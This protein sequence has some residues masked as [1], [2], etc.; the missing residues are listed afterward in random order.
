MPRRWTLLLLLL[1]VCLLLAPALA[2]RAATTPH[3][4]YGFNVAGVD[5]A[6]LQAMGFDWIKLFGPPGYRLPLHVLIRVDATAAAASDSGLAALRAQ[7]AG[8]AASQGAYIEAYEIGNEPNL[9]ASYGWAA[10]PVAADYARVLCG[11]AEAIHAHDPQATVVS[12]GLAPV[13]RVT[14]NWQG[15]AGHNGAYQDEREFLREFIA[16]GGAACADA[17]GYHPYGYS[18]N[19]DAAPDIPSGNPDQNCDNGFCFRGVEKIHEILAAEGYADKPIW[20][21]EFGWIVTP[22]ADCL[23]HPSFQG[24][25]WQ[26]V[27][28]AEQAANLQGA[29]TYADAHMPWM[30]PMFVFNLNFNQASYYEP[31]EQMRF[32]AVQGR[33]AESALAGMPKNPVG[34]VLD[35]DTSPRVLLA[36]TSEQP[37]AL[38]LAIELRN[39]G[40]APYSFSAS[41]GGPLSLSPSPTSGSVPPGA[42]TLVTVSV[43]A[44]GLP[45]GSHESLLTIAAP[46]TAGSPATVP[47]RLLLVDEVYRVYLPVLP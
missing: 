46:E 7:L 16:A 34:A 37:L 22:P 10:P 31:C 45:P 38:S 35:V 3:L 27:S 21:T 19:Y 13:G 20:A 39:P 18:A 23:S 40:T 32:Y 26:L 1:I 29:Y 5:V 33:P 36:A 4:G 12:A 11:A 15:H 6:R 28:E 30:G 24:R 44:N 2:T 17:I 47:I 14:G 9:D 8:M 25:Q 43:A 41:A 42:T